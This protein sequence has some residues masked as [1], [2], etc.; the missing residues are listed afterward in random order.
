MPYPLVSPRMMMNGS[1][2]AIAAE[3]AN[4][5]APSAGPASLAASGLRVAR[6]PPASRS[7]SC[8]QDR[9][10]GLEAVLV[11]VPARPL[12]G[13]E[14]EVPLEERDLEE[15]LRPSSS[16]PPHRERTAPR[17]RRSGVLRRRP[18][19]EPTLGAVPPTRR[20]LWPRRRRR[21]STT[22]SA[23][24]REREETEPHARRRRRAASTV[25]RSWTTSAG[26]GLATVVATT[27]RPVRQRRR[28]SPPLELDLHPLDRLAGAHPGGREEHLGPC[29]AQLVRARARGRPGGLDR[30]VRGPRRPPRRP[31]RELRQLGEGGGRVHAGGTKLANCP[32]AS[33]QRHLR[34]LLRR[35]RN[36]PRGDGRVL[37][38][39]VVRPADLPLALGARASSTRPTPRARSS[40]TSRTSS[41]STR[42]TRSSASSTRCRGTRRRS[43]SSAA[44][45]LLWSSLSLFSALE[46]AFNIVYGRPNRLVPARQGPRERAP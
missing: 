33:D 43:R 31:G 17:P 3:A 7:P 22:S 13:A 27:A 42:S 36:P 6:Q 10:I 14:R 37:R 20:R 1:P 34:P 41:R 11:E 24:G 30:P 9:R 40:R 25:R 8:A 38:A 2:D 35:A 12:A 26:G 15:A 19:P 18:R 16:T 28:A 29:P 44:V 39:R 5:T 21:R 4:A 46:S 32:S 45:A 23:N